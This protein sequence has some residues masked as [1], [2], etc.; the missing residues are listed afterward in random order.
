MPWYFTEKTCVGTDGCLGVSTT[1]EVGQFSHLM[2]L[3][4]IIHSNIFT[5]VNTIIT[6]LE[7]VSNLSLH[8]RL[9]R[10]KANMLMPTCDYPEGFHHTA[11]IDTHE[12]GSETFLYYVNDSDGE[13]YFFNLVD[14]NLEVIHKQTPKSNMGVLFPSDM[15]HASSS[16]TQ[17][18]RIVMNFVFHPR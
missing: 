2:Y 7:R 13:T 4:G 3:D 17:N 12:E 9:S 10:V 16:P 18:R 11:H 6:E 1:K 15:Y 14:D 8:N 5:H